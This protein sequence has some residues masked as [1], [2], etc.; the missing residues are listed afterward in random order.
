M[1]QKD[2]QRAALGGVSS[3]GQ[4]RRMVMWRQMLCHR[5][6]MP[7]MGRQFMHL[8][9]N[10]QQRLRC[11]TQGEQQQHE[12]LEQRSGPAHGRK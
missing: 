12:G 8:S 7:A 6:G 1:V 3:I 5:R 4:R 11:H 2:V 9:Q 10:A